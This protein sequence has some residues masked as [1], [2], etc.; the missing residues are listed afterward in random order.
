LIDHT[1]SKTT[2]RT[3]DIRDEKTCD[4]RSRSKSKKVVEE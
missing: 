3:R 2:S 4:T 1:P